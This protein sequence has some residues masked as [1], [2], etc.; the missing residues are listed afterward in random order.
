MAPNNVDQWDSSLPHIKKFLAP[1][2][3]QLEP[4]IPSFLDIELESQLFLEAVSPSLLFQNPKEKG[5]KLAIDLKLILREFHFRYPPKL[6]SP[7]GFTSP[8]RTPQ[9]APAAG[10]GLRPRRQ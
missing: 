6:H 10:H 2:K 7:A 9:P 8:A 1:V 4:G 5:G 3:Y